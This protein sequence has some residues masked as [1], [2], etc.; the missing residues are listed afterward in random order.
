MSEG[1]E[2]RAQR[3][4]FLTNAGILLID[5]TLYGYGHQ[6]VELIPKSRRASV[7]IG[8]GAF[9]GSELKFAFIQTHE[10]HV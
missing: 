5:A 2:K 3:C 1:L 6:Q 10:D 7:V 9:I 4:G 8:T